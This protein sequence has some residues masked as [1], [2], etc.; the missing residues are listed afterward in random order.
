MKDIKILIFALFIN[1]QLNGQD[2]IIT[3]SYNNRIL[4]N[5]AFT[6]YEENVYRLS[7]MNRAQYITPGIYSFNTLTLDKMLCKPSKN[8]RIGLGLIAT[9][10]EQGDGFLKTINCGGLLA[11][12]EEINKFWTLSLGMQLSGIYQSVD[13]SKFVFSDQITHLGIDK[14]K[15]SANA[16]LNRNV[17]YMGLDFNTGILIKGKSRKNNLDRRFVFGISFYHLSKP[18]IGLLND[19]SIPIRSNV[20]SGVIWKADNYEHHLACGWIQQ[21]NFIFQTFNINYK[22][23]YKQKV[24]GG[25]GL[26]DNINS[27]FSNNTLFIPF[28]IGFEKKYNKKPLRVTFSYDLNV[29]GLVGPY[30]IFELSIVAAFNSNC[31]NSKSKELKCVDF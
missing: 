5:P 14:D 17:G 2:F 1:L 11:F 22:V 12:H 9:R 31:S 23:I 27:Y 6:G 24:I 7:L 26:R 4:T 18:N 20:H 19:H 29:G 15:L 16:A 13:W 30:G 3:Q 28:I 21:D 25:I 8:I 10:E